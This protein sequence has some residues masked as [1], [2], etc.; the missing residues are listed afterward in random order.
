MR[1]LSKL[2]LTAIAAGF[3]FSTAF[4]GTFSKSCIEEVMNLS[5]EDGFDM[6]DFIK[7]LLPAAIKVKAQAKAPLQFLLGPGPDNK[8][9]DIGLT[10][11]CLKALPESPGEIK[12]L[13]MNVGLEVGKSVAAG[14]SVTKQ[15]KTA[16]KKD[17]DDENYEETDKSGKKDSRDDK[18]YA[19][20][21]TEAIAAVA[22]QANG[23]SI[24]TDTRDKKTYNITKIGSQTWMAENLNF[25]ASNSKCY[26]N[27]EENCQKYGR[28]YN[29]ETAMKACPAGW[30]L[31][32]ETE[33]DKLIRY[34]DGRTGT[35]SPYKSETAGK[36]LKAKSNW[37]SVGTGS[38]QDTYG[39]SALPGGDYNANDSF[40]SAGGL[41][42]WWSAGKYSNDHAYIRY[43]VYNSEG[44]LYSNYGKSDL[45]SVRC[46]R[47]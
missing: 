33:W 4:A 35:S 29:W 41:G 16:L 1:T 31:P 3:A 44:A 19:D 22:K 2:T 24:L 11:G 20:S 37:S 42:F 27:K 30:H 46:V 45:V 18:T 47:D 21:E 10:V 39:F 40:S 26:D 38:G 17:D 14:K 32:N 15:T 25:A 36:Y 34:V 5:E 8:V 43:M 7:E 13:L 12:S 23:G 28:L 9:T 6:Q